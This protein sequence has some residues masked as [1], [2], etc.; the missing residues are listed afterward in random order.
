[1]RILRGKDQ[2]PQA[3][4]SPAGLSTVGM[5]SGMVGIVGGASVVVGWGAAS[6]GIGEGI[7]VVGAG[8]R[9]EKVII[10]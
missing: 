4:L 2:I 9:L 1:M 7:V 10:K 3:P 6:S 8:E 5:R